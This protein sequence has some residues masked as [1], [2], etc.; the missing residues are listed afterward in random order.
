MKRTPLTRKTPLKATKPVNPINT[1][2]RKSEFARAYH[3]K[4]RVAWVQALRC[5][6]GCSGTP[7]DNAHVV[8]DGMGRKA[9]Y[10]TIIPLT[11]TCHG[12]VHQKGW[13]A[14]G[15]NKDEAL[16]IARQVQRMWER[17]SGETAE[18]NG[19]SKRA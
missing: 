11:R 9:D 10:T 6:C 13:A 17:H 14:I 7:C 3:S 15:L 18:P 4:A 2:R 16:A 1:E 19:A 5:A 12:K 8:G